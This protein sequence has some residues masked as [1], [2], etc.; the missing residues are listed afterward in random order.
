MAKKAPAP[1]EPTTGSSQQL[2][3][4]IA[5]VKQLQGFIKEHGTLDDA[6]AAADR[7]HGLI[8][9]TGDFN[10]FKEALKLVGT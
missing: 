6:L 2:F 9:V 5:V 1:Q 7:F 3:D 4:A 8:E 10:G